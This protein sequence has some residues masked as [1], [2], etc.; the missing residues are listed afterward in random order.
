MFLEYENYSSFSWEHKLEVFGS[1]ELAELTT[2]SLGR[3]LKAKGSMKV[4]SFATKMR[5][6]P[7]KT[8]T[9]DGPIHLGLA[10]P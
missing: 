7:K 6:W 8:A 2:A 3:F 1:Y 4:M 9:Q 10:F 5:P